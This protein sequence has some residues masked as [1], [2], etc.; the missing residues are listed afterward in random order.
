MADEL[1]NLPLDGGGRRE[2]P[3]GGVVVPFWRRLG[4]V[5]LMREEPIA[6]RGSAR[7]SSSHEPAGLPKTIRPAEIAKMRRTPRPAMPVAR[8]TSVVIMSCP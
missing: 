1:I 7:A 8:R 2:A 4:D 5:A 3:G 6:G